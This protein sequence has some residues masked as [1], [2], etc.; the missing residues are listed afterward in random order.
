[1]SQLQ[2]PQWYHAKTTNNLTPKTH[3]H[4]TAN[5]DAPDAFD[6]IHGGNNLD[7][8]H[9]QS[10]VAQPIRGRDDPST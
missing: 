6:D 1:M 10:L 8:Q 9:G 7:Q 2:Q 4:M 5:R 3:V